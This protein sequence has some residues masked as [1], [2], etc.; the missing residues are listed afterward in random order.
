MTKEEFIQNLQYF[1]DPANGIG[2]AL[3]F[4]VEDGGNQLIKFADIEDNTKNELKDRF[5]ES[6]NERFCSDVD[7][8]YQNISEADDRSN[9]VYKYD[10]EEVPEKLNILNEILRE[11]EQPFFQFN[12]GNLN[13]IRGY[14]ITIGNDQRKIA[15]YKKHYPVNLLKRDRFMLIPDN[16]RLV[17][18]Q[19]DIVAIDKSFDLIMIE[20]TLIV[21]NL[22]TLE[23]FFGFEDVVK[24][25]AAQAIELISARLLMEDVEQL[26][27]MAVDLP[28]A[29]KLMRMRNSPVLAIPVNQVI[30]FIQQHPELKGRL[31]LNN[32]GDKVLLTTGVSRKLFLKLM[33]DD[34]L[35]SQLTELQYDSHAKDQLSNQGNI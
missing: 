28:T 23:R 34:Y 16:R 33:N 35:Y 7:F 14:L 1:L 24:S 27:Q 15:L 20:E 4:V 30:Q 19:S 3:Y 31:S 25:K 29:R 10:I 5:L 26:K 22:K 9:V 17:K 2:C 8:H 18:I 21:T 32:E 11:E 12:G 6:I 13:Q